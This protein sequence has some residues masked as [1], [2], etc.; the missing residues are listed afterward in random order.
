MQMDSR[1]TADPGAILWDGF[2]LQTLHSGVGR[3]A[4]DL[5]QALERAACSPRIIP[6]VPTLD[7]HFSSHI[8]PKNSR[9]PQSRIK[10]WALFWSSQWLKQYMQSRAGLCVVHGLSNYNIPGLKASRLRK[11]LTVHDLIPILQRQ[12]V[13]A[14]LGHYL[15]Y[16]LP[17]AV[18]AADAIICVSR[19]TEN[20]LHDHY[21]SSRGR[22]LVIPNGWP[23]PT[24]KKTPAGTHL[25][26]I[27][28]Q[29]SYKR[30]GLIPEILQQLPASFCW[31]V[32]TDAGGAAL[33]KS[34]SDP[35]L[36]VQSQ[37]SDKDMQTLH[38]AA[39]LYVHPS[40]LE[41]FCLPAAAS[42]AQCVPVI[43]TQGSGID[44]VVGEAGMGLSPEAGSRS[45]AAAIL[46][47]LANP[48]RALLC[49]RRNQSASSWDDVA[50]RT[51]ALYDKLGER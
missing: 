9:W 42:I 39:D 41:G 18:S 12:E 49:T 21:P 25:L 3:H 40:L 19:W 10:P 28:R 29:E 4:W 15:R 33:L 46:E 27:S 35:R 31:T 38:A 43:F 13:S 50:A 48:D 22:T 36:L 30:L 47:L 34:V 14:A 32:V 44:E 8:L 17:R 51:R 24:E 37:I 7:F 6:S 23:R 1:P 16:Q 11:V 45:W 20:T 5:L 2:G 26:T